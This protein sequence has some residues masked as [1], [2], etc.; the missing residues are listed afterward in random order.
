MM[1]FDVKNCVQVT[2]LYYLYIK[3]VQSHSFI[4]KW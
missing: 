2:F 1:V 4:S 3:I